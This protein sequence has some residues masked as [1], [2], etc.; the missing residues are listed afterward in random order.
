MSNVDHELE[1]LYEELSI[2]QDGVED[3]TETI[4]EI[5]SVQLNR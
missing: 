5:I 3:C 2:R 4:K 1:I